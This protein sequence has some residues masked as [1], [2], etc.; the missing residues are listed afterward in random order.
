MDYN[1]KSAIQNFCEFADEVV[2]ATIPCKDGTR[3]ALA[4]MES[5]YENFKVVET[6]ISLS[7]NR[8]DGKLKTAALQ[9]TTNPIKIIADGDER[10]LLPQKEIWEKNFE[11]LMELRKDGVD[12]LLIPVVDLWG[13]KDHIRVDKPIGQKFRIHLDTVKSRGVIPQAELGGGLFDT[14]MSDSTEPIN[15]MGHLARFVSV[16]EGNVMH[17]LFARGLIGQ[18]YVIHLGYLDLKHRAEKISQFWKPHWEARSGKEEDVEMEVEILKQYPTI[19]HG[20]LTDNTP[21]PVVEEDKG[22]NW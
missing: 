22:D 16:V 5:Q 2:C 14:S 11:L 10:F 6:D 17:P 12:G 15:E 9:A 21:L 4:E 1:Y 19:K 13:D 7:D 20:L 18:P 3:E 8:F